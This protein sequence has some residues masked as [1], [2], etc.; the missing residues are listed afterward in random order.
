MKVHDEASHWSLLDVNR[1]A[2]NR[3]SANFLNTRLSTNDPSNFSRPE[4][5]KNFS[6]KKPKL[7]A[8]VS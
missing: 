2:T 1:T 7:N 4:T 8:A 5:A 3:G 6:V